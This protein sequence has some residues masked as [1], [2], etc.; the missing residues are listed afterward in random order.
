MRKILWVLL[1]VSILLTGVIFLFSSWV[2]TKAQVE[3]SSVLVVGTVL[4]TQNQPVP[5]V[6]VSLRSASAEEP[7]AEVET[8]PDGRYALPVPDR[9]FREST[10]PRRN[11]AAGGNRNKSTAER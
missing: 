9:A 3:E 7:L 11:H 6:A 5:R 1:P 2:D 8:Q 4:D 10:L